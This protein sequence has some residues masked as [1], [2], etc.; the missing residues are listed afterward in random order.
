V[1]QTPDDGEALMAAVEAGGP[2]A[3]ATTWRDLG[4]PVERLSRLHLGDPMMDTCILRLY[5]SATSVMHTWGSEVERAAL[6]TGLVIAPSDD[7]FRDPE[8]TVRAAARAGATIVP[9]E[10]VGHFW[11]LQDPQRAAA[12]LDAFW[13]DI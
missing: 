13:K 9:L 12:V 1:W 3:L 4:V 7:P 5:R 11:M 2:A 10:G 6:T 8:L